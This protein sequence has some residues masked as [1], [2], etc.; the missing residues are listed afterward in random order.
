M[1]A[2]RQLLLQHR[3]AR[4]RIRELDQ[5]LADAMYSLLWIIGVDVAVDGWSHFRLVEETDDHPAGIGLMYV[6][7][8]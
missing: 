5:E 2:V 7:P 6:L 3:S 4:T 8:T 1:S